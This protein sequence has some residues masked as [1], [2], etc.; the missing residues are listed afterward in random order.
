MYKHQLKTRN[1]SFDI[2]A[3]NCAANQ[4]RSL[5]E[6][7][8]KKRGG[9]NAEFCELCTP[10]LTARDP[11]K[12][13]P[14]RVDS[15][16]WTSRPEQLFTFTCELVAGRETRRQMDAGH[17]HFPS[18][19]LVWL[20]PGDTSQFLE[21]LTFLLWMRNGGKSEKG[22]FSL[23]K[24]TQYSMKRGPLEI[25]SHQY[26]VLILNHSQVGFFPPLLL[27]SHSSLPF[28]IGGS[29]NSPSP[30]NSSPVGEKKK[31]LEVVLIN[32]LSLSI[33]PPQL[34][35]PPFQTILITEKTHPARPWI[36]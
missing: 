20:L 30:R 19:C 28:F 9:H 31:S 24:K 17:S 26:S 6:K 2:F 12:R 25:D 7:R 34:R 3:L 29:D 4:S 27:S 1:F 21:A 5:Q 11:R 35:P 22:S 14:W 10:F 15:F 23:V 13:L 18:H 16:L 32:A 8:D 36:F 33:P